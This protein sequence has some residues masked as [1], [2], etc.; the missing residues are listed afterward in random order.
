MTG[1]STRPVLI[2]GGAG[3]I[4]AN[5]AHRLARSGHAVRVLDDLS[6]RGV[7]RNLGWLCARHGDRIDARISD[8]RDPGSVRDAVRGAAAV[9]HFAG[10]TAVTTS[11]VDVWATASIRDRVRCSIEHRDHHAGCYPE[12]VKCCVRELVRATLQR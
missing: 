5:L 4:G 2:T 11:L 3:F 6:R 10:Q 9:F 12:I 7:E 8:V 1:G